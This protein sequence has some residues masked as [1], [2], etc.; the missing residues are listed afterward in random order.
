M[1]RRA[2]LLLQA[3]LLSFSHAATLRLEAGP[4]SASLVKHGD[5][6]IRSAPPQGYVDPSVVQAVYVACGAESCHR[7]QAAVRSFLAQARLDGGEKPALHL[8]LDEACAARIESLQKQEPS[9][10]EAAHFNT[11]IVSHLSKN[12]VGLNL[13]KQCASLRLSLPRLLPDL[14]KIL[15]MDTDTLVAG[16]LRQ[17]WKL[18]PYLWAFGENDVTW[19]SGAA[20]CPAD[21]R[22]HMPIPAPEKDRLKTCAFGGNGINSGVMLLNQATWRR[23]NMENEVNDLIQK[24][25]HNGQDPKVLRMGDQDIL[26]MLAVAHDKD[27]YTMMLPCE[28]NSIF[29]NRYMCFYGSGQWQSFT[30]QHAVNPT[31]ASN[32]R[33]NSRQPVV[34]HAKFNVNRAGLPCWV[35]L[36]QQLLAAVGAVSAGRA[37]GAGSLCE[38]A[39]GCD[40]E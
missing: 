4:A 33:R 22:R 3:W 34:V 32:L 36:E 18:D 37:G 16:S 30:K 7:G 6:Q 35:H 1:G 10:A 38:V 39:G 25:T 19:Y 11:Y 2:R 17:L 9:L 21:W 14:P 24:L 27:G 15:Y 12:Q 13:Y 29:L 8:F 5:L 26:N 31:N 40:L 28:M 20:R 23:L